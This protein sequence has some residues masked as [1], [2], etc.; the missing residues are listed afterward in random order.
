MTTAAYEIRFDER[1]GIDRPVLHVDYETLSD[2]VQQEFEM[3]CQQ[4]CA[5]IP[6]RIKRFEREY[7]ERF[8]ALKEAEDD[9]IFFNLTDEMNEI[10]KI[11]CDLNIL[12]L[13]IEGT[14][15]P[16]SSHA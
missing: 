16:S 4:I 6:E 8:E 7:M 5:R 12:F 11:I 14:F 2:E 10:S 15:I 13:Y 3:K 1:L 9:E